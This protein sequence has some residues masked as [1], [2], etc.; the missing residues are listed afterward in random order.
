[1]YKHYI[2]TTIQKYRVSK[3]FWKKFRKDLKNLQKIC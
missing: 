1:M 2:Y 3:I